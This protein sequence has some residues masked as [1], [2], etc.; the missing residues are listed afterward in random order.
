VSKS[1]GYNATVKID[2][3]T[4]PVNWPIPPREDPAAPFL[5]A[6]IDRPDDDLPRLVYA[7]WLD[8][9]GE[10][11]R[12]EYIRVQCELAGIGNVPRDTWNLKEKRR[13]DQQQALRRRERELLRAFGVEW[14]NRDVGVVEFPDPLPDGVFQRGFVNNLT[15]SWEGWRRH[16]AALLAACPIRQR[17]DGTADKPAWVAGSGGTVRLTTWPVGWMVTRRGDTAEPVYHPDYPGVAFELPA[18]FA[19]LNLQARR[20]Y[21]NMAMSAE[22]LGEAG[23]ATYSGAQ[24]AL[25]QFRSRHGPRQ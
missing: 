8:E 13:F 14:A 5:R 4:F 23:N 11:E 12:A 6:I 25:E 22:L 15:L 2:G 10:P 3:Q 16:A 18:A 9:H 21:A 20:L 17:N 24:A 7:D 19:P 1:V